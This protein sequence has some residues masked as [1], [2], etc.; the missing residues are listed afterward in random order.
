M[1]LLP[2]NSVN[3]SGFEQL[4]DHDRFKLTRKSNDYLKDVDKVMKH[5]R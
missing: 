4:R 5:K 3:I 1:S 2:K